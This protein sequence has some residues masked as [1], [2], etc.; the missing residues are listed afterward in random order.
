MTGQDWDFDPYLQH[1]SSFFGLSAE[2]E[3]QDHALAAFDDSGGITQSQWM[4][5][6]QHARDELEREREMHEAHQA[7]SILAK[8][9]NGGGIASLSERERE[10]L[11]RVS[12]RLRRQRDRETQD[13]QML[14]E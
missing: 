9:H 10:V 11:N 3:L 4:L 8:M 5:E 12:R 2:D 13:A 7:D 1:E 14:G 6:K